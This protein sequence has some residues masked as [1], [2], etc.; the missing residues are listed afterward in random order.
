MEDRIEGVLGDAARGIPFD[1]NTP[2]IMMSVM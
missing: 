2:T 1:V